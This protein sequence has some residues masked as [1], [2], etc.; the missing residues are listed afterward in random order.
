MDDWLLNDLQLF[1]HFNRNE[2]TVCVCMHTHVCA[3]NHF[4][5]RRYTTRCP[6]TCQWQL[7]GIAD[8]HCVGE[9]SVVEG[10]VQMPLDK[11]PIPLATR[12]IFSSREVQMVV[13]LISG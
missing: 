4:I 6:N 7:G 3:C 11:L 8:E 2:L 9:N 12:T 1:L 13:V 5:I 10:V